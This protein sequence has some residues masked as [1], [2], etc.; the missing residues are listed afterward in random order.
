VNGKLPF[1]KP[2]AVPIFKTFETMASRK[3]NAIRRIAMEKNRESK[4]RL[5]E[6]AS[7]VRKHTKTRRQLE[8]EIL[9]F[10][11]ESS[12]KEG[13]SRKPG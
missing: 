13:K 7:G 4:K 12:T 6:A 2:G 9:Q 1:E 11:N 5:T 8:K 3:G 10:L